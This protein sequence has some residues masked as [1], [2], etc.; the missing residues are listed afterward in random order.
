MTTGTVEQSA[1]YYA[2]SESN[3]KP[4]V[5][6]KTPKVDVKNP[7]PALIAD[8]FV[9]FE[10]KSVHDVNHNTKTFRFALPEGTTELGLPTASAV[11][12][13]FVK[14]TKPDGKPDV[15]IRPYTPLEDPADGYTGYFD[16]LIK[17]YPNGPMST[18]IFSLKPGDKLDVKG[19]IPKWPYKANEFKKVGL[20][21]GGTGI[22]PNLQVIQRILS[23]PEDKTHIALVFANIAEED[24]LLK[25]YF[26]DLQKKH[27]DRFNVYYVLEKPP[28]GWTQGVGYVSEQI[29]KEQLPKPGEGKVF[30]CGPNQ[31]L[32]AISGTKT[33]DYKQGE[34]GGILK[35]LGYTEN[36]VY[37][38]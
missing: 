16:L 27:S 1:A 2:T 26:D 38:F 33:P 24:I 34:V 9:S 14:G 37:K 12:T 17:K 25:S 32:A 7:K 18:H 19:P 28:K 23:N 29:V 3:T 11:V 36:D 20:I 4:T 21:A 5:T 30:I 6:S 31:M 8:Q 13:K 10:L 15:V 22:T 35:K